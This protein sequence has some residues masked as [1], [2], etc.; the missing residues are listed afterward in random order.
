MQIQFPEFRD[1]LATTQYPFAD[2][3]TLSNAAGDFFLE[4]VFLDASL[5]PIGGQARLYISSV[6][7]AGST[8]TITVGDQASASLASCS[9]DTLSPPDILRFVDAHG[10]PAGLI[11]S[12]AS[13]LTVFQSWNQ[14]L[15]TFKIADTELAV[16]CC[17]PTPEIGVRGIILE[18]GTVFTG[19]VWL[20]GED[21]VVL[22]KTS[23]KIDNPVCGQPPLEY[24]VVRIDIV[25]DPLFRRRLCT[26]PGLFSTP[27]FIRTITIK[28]GGRTFVCQP[29]AA[30]D[31]QITVGNNLAADTV[32]RVHPT[33]NGLQ[34]G[35]VGDKLANV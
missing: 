18:D 19:D 7:M 25:G 33:D 28:Q 17:L 24:A 1:E 11:V 21:G 35:V 32:L 22:R 3:A 13:L 30:G 9:F 34:I 2:T 29:D 26:A 20:V 27:Q 10:R 14:G 23:L 8:C 31:F 4:G 12:Q 6:L 16:R 5:Y 15:H